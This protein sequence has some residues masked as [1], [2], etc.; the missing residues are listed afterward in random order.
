LQERYSPDARHRLAQQLDPFRD[1]FAGQG[2][3]A[4]DVS[5]RARQ[6]GDDTGHQRIAAR[7]HHDG[8]RCGGILGRHHGGRPARHDQIDVETS[9][10]GREL[11]K[12]LGAAIGRAIVDDEVLALDVAEVPQTLAQ[13]IEIGGVRRRRN[14]LQ[15][16]DAVNLAGLLCAGRE[17]PRRRAAEERDEIAAFCMTG[18]EHC[19][20]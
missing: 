12:A 11:R 14:H 9:Q 19:E 5:A 10:L 20:S 6:P 3:Q 13:R 4:S 16:A 15:D 18:K 1:Q 7:G 2:A 17:P 8:N